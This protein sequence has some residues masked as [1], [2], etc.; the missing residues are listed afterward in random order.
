M[1]EMPEVK[2][3]VELSKKSLNINDNMNKLTMTLKNPTDKLAF[4][5]GI[6]LDQLPDEIFAFYNDNY[7]TLLPNEKRKVEI[8]LQNIGGISEGREA[9]FVIYGWNVEEKKIPLMIE[10][11]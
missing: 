8:E 4:F 9:N 5:T 10:V 7:F 2:L 1:N 3:N 6:K 11:K